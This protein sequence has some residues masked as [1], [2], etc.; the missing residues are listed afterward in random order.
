MLYHKKYVVTNGHNIFVTPPAE[1]WSLFLCGFE[2][3]LGL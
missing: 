3:E 2:S 1:R